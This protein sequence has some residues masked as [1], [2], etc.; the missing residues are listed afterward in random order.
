MCIVIP[1]TSLLSIKVTMNIK[2]GQTFL[3]VLIQRKVW[4]PSAKVITVQTKIAFFISILANQAK[5]LSYIKEL[6]PKDILWFVEVGNP[7]R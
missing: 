1:R 7:M 6:T 5:T 3:E 2:E 4:L